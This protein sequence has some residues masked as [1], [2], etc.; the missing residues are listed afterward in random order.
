MTMIGTVQNPIK[1]KNANSENSRMARQNQL[2]QQLKFYQNKINSDYQYYQQFSKI[3]QE[4]LQ[5]KDKNSELRPDAFPKPIEPERGKNHR[6]GIK[7]IDRRACGSD[8]LESATGRIITMNQS[9]IKLCG[10]FNF[11]KDIQ[12][13]S[14]NNNPTGHQSWGEP[15]RL[16][17]QL[18]SPAKLNIP[19]VLTIFSENCPS[20][21]GD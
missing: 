3:E 14:T 11:L 9:S 13:P 15:V 16:C 1:C 21:F 5:N 20:G 17:L 19:S 18:K 6:R 12:P 2:N 7:T 4:A 10:H 8:S